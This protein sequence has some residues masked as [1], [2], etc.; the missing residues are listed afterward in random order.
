MPR[1]IIIGVMEHIE[2]AGIHSGDSA[3]ALPPYSLSKEVI[4]RL[5]EQTR[6][7]AKALRVRGLMNVQYAIKDND[8]YVI[9]VNPRASRTVPFVSKATGIPWAKIAAKVMAGESL[10]T[11]QITEQP[12][13]A[14]TSV[15]EVVFPFSKFPGVD[16]I[17][18]PEMR[19]TGEVMGIDANF[20]MAFAKSQIAAGGALPTKGRIFISVNSRDK[21]EIVP[22]AKSLAECGFE[23]I[24]TD[25]TFKELR[26]NDI[27]A[28]LIPKLAEG[29]PNIAD[30]IKNGQV[31]LLINTPT[32]KGPQ[33]DEGK[34]RSMAILN[35][36]PIITTL[37]GARAAAAAIRELQKGDWTVRPIQA[38]FGAKG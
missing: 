6:A 36:V 3:C 22:V 18:G 38:Y 33:T 32:R 25:G 28:T 29:R 17:L 30:F 16:V 4:H 23:I 37:T 26:R 35:K 15:K 27:P 34:I 2:E 19:S 5:K 1:A 20:P 31:Q 21:Q 11:L 7:L 12:D 14:H 13:P 10:A 8:I 9:E 24:A